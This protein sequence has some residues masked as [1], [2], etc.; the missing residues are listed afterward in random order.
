MG[1]F[2][3]SL[4]QWL[5]MCAKNDDII[6]YYFWSTTKLPHLYLKNIFAAIDFTSES[7]FSKD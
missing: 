5:K 1:F 4:F 6:H 3:T 2:R 7:H